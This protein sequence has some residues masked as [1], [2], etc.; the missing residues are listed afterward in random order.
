MASKQAD[1]LEKL[2]Y[3]E[4]GHATMS[5]LIRR[6][7]VKKYVPVDRSLILPTFTR[8]SI[9]GQSADW[10]KLT[11]G[12][13]S[14]MTVSQVLLAGALAKEIKFHPYQGSSLDT[15]GPSSKRAL[16]LISSYIEEYGGDKMSIAKRDKLAE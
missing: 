1:P 10:G 9:E 8:I 2:A 16:H 15:D 13:G 5:Y 11:P 4:A 14:L 12:L 6:G 7:F 3:Q